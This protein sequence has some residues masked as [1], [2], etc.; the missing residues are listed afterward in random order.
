MWGASLN[1]SGST[2]S[3]RTVTLRAK[4]NDI[5]VSNTASTVVYKGE[6]TT[7]S[8]INA[9]SIVPFIE[10]RTGALSTT[11]RVYGSFKLYLVD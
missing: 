2:N 7:T 6:F 4:T 5:T 8:A 9:G 11:T 10:N 1:T 3:E